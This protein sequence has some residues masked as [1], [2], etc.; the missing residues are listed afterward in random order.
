MSPNA[1]GSKA[2][3]GSGPVSLLFPRDRAVSSD[4]APGGGDAAVAIDRGATIG[5]LA[6]YFGGF[7]DNALMRLAELFQTVPSILLVIAILSIGDPSL[8]LIAFAI[9]LSSWPMVARLVRSQFL[10]LRESDFVLA[11]RSLGYGTGRIIISEILPNALPTVIVAT[12]VMVANGILA[13]AGLSFLGLGDNNLVSW[14]SMVGN[15]RQVLR[16]EWF[17]SAI[18]GIAIILTVLSFNI[19][20]DRLNDIL[21]PRAELA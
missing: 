20:G 12:S 21:N 4:A 17:V 10:T 14:G 7:V 3:L 19:M 6:G 1:D 18:P 9:G 16:S 5:A 8:P 15:G 13:E 2:P 11:A